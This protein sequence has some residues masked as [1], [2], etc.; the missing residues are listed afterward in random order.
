M[1][2]RTRART[3]QEASSVE[4]A[5][6]QR[7]QNV[8]VHNTMTATPTEDW[9]LYPDNVVAV[10]NST[11]RERRTE[12]IH[13]QSHTKP[14][15][16]N[17]RGSGPTMPLTPPGSSPAQS[18]HERTAEKKC[19]TRSQELHDRPSSGPTAS[20]VVVN[21]RAR[22][23]TSYPYRLPTPDISDVDED[24]YWACCGESSRK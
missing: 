19:A 18:E 10:K 3:Q 23:E 14:K 12:K 8:I 21:R 22:T 9:V 24:E 1:A 20:P 17:K 11:V 4:A 5:V 13:M 16:R 15:L 6:K 2:S 7:K